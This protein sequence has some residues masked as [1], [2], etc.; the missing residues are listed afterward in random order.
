MGG[1]LAHPDWPRLAGLAAEECGREFGEAELERAF[2]EMLCAYSAEAQKGAAPAADQKLPH[3]TFRR[4][5]GLL[6]VDEEACGRVTGG[7]KRAR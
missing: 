3:W 5:Y 4:T 2:K 1:T 6:G 7:S